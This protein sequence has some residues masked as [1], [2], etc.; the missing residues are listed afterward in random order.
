MSLGAGS[1]GLQ[2]H[3]FCS[4]SLAFASVLKCSLFLNK[5]VYDYN[6][7]HW[8]RLL[9]IS[10]LA[11]S[12]RGMDGLRSSEAKLYIGNLYRA[13]LLKIKGTKLKY[14]LKNLSMERISHR[15]IC[16][17]MEWNLEFFGRISS[18]ASYIAFDMCHWAISLEIFNAC[19]R[20][21]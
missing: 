10:H 15:K 11:T 2:L 17:Q 19:F 18:F 16:V 7:D 12:C 5:L 6:L 9:A 1:V 4:F 20:G 8:V 14:L 21:N 3:A 13:N